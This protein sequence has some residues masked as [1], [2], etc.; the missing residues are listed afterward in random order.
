ME[1]SSAEHRIRCTNSTATR[2]QAHLLIQ[3]LYDGLDD[4]VLI[5]A[6]TC[7][8]RG[9]VFPLFAAADV[10]SDHPAIALELLRAVLD[11]GVTLLAF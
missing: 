4:P 3:T 2:T 11:R 6:S 5:L 9:G 7:K 10:E 1:A 8:G